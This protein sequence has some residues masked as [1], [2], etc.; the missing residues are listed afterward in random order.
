MGERVKEGRTSADK[1]IM[2]SPFCPQLP[3]VCTEPAWGS[4]TVSSLPA[5]HDRRHHQISQAERCAALCFYSRKQAMI[6]PSP[7]WRHLN[8]LQPSQLRGGDL[9]RES[10]PGRPEISRVLCFLTL[11]LLFHQLLCGPA[12]KPEFPETGSR[13]MNCCFFSVTLGKIRVFW[14]KSLQLKCTVKECG[15]IF[16]EE[17]TSLIHAIFK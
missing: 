14:T 12:M 11:A 6:P 3:P 10:L 2:S 17:R 1:A 5:R 7:H 9:G 8:L 15:G 4:P 16:F 13:W